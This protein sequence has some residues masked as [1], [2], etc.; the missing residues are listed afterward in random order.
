LV[1]S[2]TESLYILYDFLMEHDLEL[3]EITK[4]K[5]IE[6]LIL[7]AVKFREYFRDMTDYYDCIHDTFVILIFFQH[8]LCT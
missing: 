3:D 8:T 5:V 7:F 4:A 2:Q 6:H 1:D